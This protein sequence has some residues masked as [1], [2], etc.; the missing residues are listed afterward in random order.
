MDEIRKYIIALD[1]GGTKINGAI[2]D[3]YGSIIFKKKIPTEAEKGAEKVLKNIYAVIDDLLEKSKSKGYFIEGI[4][5]STFGQLDHINGVIKYATNTIPD[6]TGFKLK[7]AIEEKF[8][9]NTV[10]END[11][12]CAAWGEVVF[13]SARNYKDIIILTL[14]TG[15]GGA[16]LTKGKL[17]G[18]SNGY[19][20]L[21]GHTSIEPYGHDCNCGWNRLYRVL[22][23]GLGF[24]KSF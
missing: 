3:F 24:G 23:F 17:Y 2:S 21:I 15:I 19:A 8:N 13:G 16:F 7:K 11:A 22:C 4:G 6:W 18:G 14:G 9:I 1:I 10:I 12:Y 5:I 20:G